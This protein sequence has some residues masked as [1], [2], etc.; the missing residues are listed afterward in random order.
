[1]D[2][3]MA[4]R[5]YKHTMMRWIPSIEAFSGDVALWSSGPDGSDDDIVGVASHKMHNRKRA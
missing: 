2:A 3:N 4:Y 1:M 5:R